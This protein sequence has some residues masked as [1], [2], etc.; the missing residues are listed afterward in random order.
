MDEEDWL[1]PCFP[2]F[3]LYDVLRGLSFILRWA[4][5]RRKPIPAKAIREVIDA[6]ERKFRDGRV[7]IERKAFDGIGSRVMN[8]AGEWGRSPAASFFPI[9]LQVSEVGQESPYLT[10]QWAEVRERIKSLTL[11]GLIA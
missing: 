2:R 5:K 7:R 8:A 3:Y 9:L 11:E 4:E 10:S 6:L 1:K